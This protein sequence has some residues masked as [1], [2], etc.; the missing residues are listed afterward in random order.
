MPTFLPSLLMGH[1]PYGDTKVLSEDVPQPCFVAPNNPE[2]I[3]VRFKLNRLLLVDSD[4]L[5]TCKIWGSKSHTSGW[6]QS[7]DSLLPIVPAFWVKAVGYRI[8]MRTNWKY[9]TPSSAF[10]HF[11]VLDNYGT[12]SRGKISTQNKCLI[13]YIWEEGNIN[14]GLK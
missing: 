14:N 2:R 8:S 12:K 13:L 7:R 5:L 1:K 4:M 6:Q 9:A 3:N 11:Y 10:C